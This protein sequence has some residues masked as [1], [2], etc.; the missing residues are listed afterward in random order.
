MIQPRA[1]DSYHFRSAFAPGIAFSPFNVSGTREQIGA[2]AP[3]DFPFA[4]AREMA[5]QLKRARPYF[6]GDYYPLTACTLDPTQWAGYQFHRPDMKEGMVM[7]LRR[8]ESSLYAGRFKLRGLKAAA[9]YEFQ[10]ADTGTTSRIKGIVLLEEGVD[11]SIDG[12]PGSRL[13]FYTEL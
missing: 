4:W 10:D 1:G 5:A 7:L 12:A 2:F 11:I 3:P 13:L 6:Y 9:E 8:P